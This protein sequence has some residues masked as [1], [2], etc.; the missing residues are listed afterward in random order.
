MTITEYL[1]NLDSLNIDNSKV[2]IIEEIYSTS[3]PED[4]QRIISNCNK[5]QFISDYRLLSFDEIVNAEEDLEVEFTELNLIPVFDCGDNDFAVYHID[6]KKW[7]LF[8]II[9][10]TPFKVKE[11]LKELLA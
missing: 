7:S 11:S 8:N 9:D 10:Y 4:I 2:N 5:T 6:T 3:L 1:D